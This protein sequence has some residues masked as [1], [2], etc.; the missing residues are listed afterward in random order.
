MKINSFSNVFRILEGRFHENAFSLIK[1]CPS[2]WTLNGAPCQ[3]YPP[4]PPFGR[5]K[6]FDEEYAGENFKISEMISLLMVAAVI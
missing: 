4:P 3:G 2:D 1:E 5:Q 6:D